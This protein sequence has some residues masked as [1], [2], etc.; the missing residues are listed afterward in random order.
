MDSALS[1]IMRKSLLTIFILSLPQLGAGSQVVEI[2]TPPPHISTTCKQVH[3][4]GR[5]G[6]PQVAVYLNDELFLQLP[7]RDSIFHTVIGFGYG[8]NSIK[9]EPISAGS[10]DPVGPGAEL[11]ILYGP[12]IE[13]KY[14]RFY[15]PYTFHDD[16]PKEGCINCHSPVTEGQSSTGD[17]VTCLGCHVNFKKRFQSHTE[18]NDEVCIGC[19]R[20]DKNLTTVAMTQEPDAN[21][22]YRCHKD[23]IG[24]F[25]A[26]FIHGPVAGGSCTVCHDPH[27]SSWEKSLLS[28]VPVLCF[29][30]HTDV[31]SHNISETVHR[32]F[33]EGKCMECHDPHATNNKWM[34]SKSSEE[35]CLRCHKV[36]G[37]LA[38]HRHPYNVKPSKRMTAE[39]ELTPR[40]RLE[41]LSC[42]DPHATKSKNL[43]RVNQ[44]DGCSGCHAEKL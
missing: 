39:V 38:S 7:V 20:L 43:L 12:Q 33:A 5:T 21:P 10:T 2:L 25:T 16:K 4:V 14:K 36:D 30:C 23:K 6:A 26:D 11:E 42:H 35:I 8:L 44:E 1:V 9:V 13:R 34:L 19:H 15:D 24:E 37:N 31:G 17:S 29:L 40:G 3:L 32:P 18:V 27:G 41:C 28:P 22:C